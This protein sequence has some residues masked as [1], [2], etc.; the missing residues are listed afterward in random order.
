VIS[1][2]IATQNSERAL[3]PTLANLVSGAAAGVVREVIVADA[4]S[5][6]KTSEIADLAGCELIVSQAPLATRLSEAAARARAS[7]LMF[8]RAGIVLDSGWI[9][10][11]A[12]FIEQAER[13]GSKGLQAAVFKKSEPVAARKSVLRQGLSMIKATLAGR[14]SAD[15]GLLI[16]K[17]I[18][19][20]LGAHR[21]NVGDPEIELLRRL[22]RSRIALLRSGAAKISEH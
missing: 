2:I 21:N 18:Y 4:T 19:E 8:M 10:E 14:A 17:R 11:V 13:A 22:G 12:R 16:S 3:V 9:E 15:Q 20:E 7:W 6:D 1:V 5:T